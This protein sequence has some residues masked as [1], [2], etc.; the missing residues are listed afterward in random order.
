MIPVIVYRERYLPHSE[1]F[2]Y[3]Q[4]I[5]MRKY[6][7]YVLCRSRLPSEK[8]FPHRHVYEFENIPKLYRQIKRLKPKC[9]YARFG[10]GGVRM[11]PLKT[12]TKLPLLTSFHGSD[13]SRQLQIKPHYRK[14]LPLLFQRGEAFTVVCE[15]MRK[16]LVSLGCSPSKI[17]TIKS[18]IDL[19]KFPFLPSPSIDHHHIR[20]L[21]VGRFTEKKGMLDCIRAFQLVLSEIPGARLTMVGDGEERHRM[22]Q[23][24]DELG[25]RSQIELKG[26]LSHRQVQEELT[27]CDLFVLASKTASDHNEEGIPNVVM[28]AMA[29]GKIVVATEHAGIPE[30]VHHLQTG[31]LVREGDPSALSHM[32]L[33]AIK[34]R[35]EWP[36]ILANARK[37]V[38]KEHNVAQQSKKLEKLIDELVQGLP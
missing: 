8:N 2:I 1:T 5:H 18:G 32:I 28:E 11:L 10:T 13:V 14:A 21:T 22:E 16:K 7:P 15:Y 20:L 4:L 3:E 25:L 35:E 24:I 38:E 19:N 37:T 33:Y 36:D 29:T 9:I 17:H 23:L 27:S 6:K 34:Q 12:Q 30:L 31:F 26:R